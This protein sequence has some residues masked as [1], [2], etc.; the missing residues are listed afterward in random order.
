MAAMGFKIVFI[1]ISMDCTGW[2]SLY[3]LFAL[4]LVTPGIKLN[5]KGIFLALSLPLLFSI[6]IARIVITIYLSLLEPEIFSFL[7]DIL[8]SW[9]LIIAILGFWLS[10]LKFEKRI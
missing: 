10:W 5:K 4:A 9:G 6:N 7:H 3:T 2:K 1:D 8:W